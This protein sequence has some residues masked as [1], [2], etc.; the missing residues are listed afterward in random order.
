M[1]ALITNSIRRTAAGAASAAAAAVYQSDYEMDSL[2]WLM[3]IYSVAGVINTIALRCCCCCN[4]ANLMKT[5]W[6]W[7]AGQLVHL[8]RRNLAQTVS[9]VVYEYSWNVRRSEIMKSR[10][11]TQSGTISFSSSEMLYVYVRWDGRSWRTFFQWFS[12]YRGISFCIGKA[13]SKSTKI[14]V[15]IHFPRFVC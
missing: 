14:L 3:Y 13:A 4:K 11:R 7:S 12:I 8:T 6:H 10:R 2:D 1:R 9:A 15:G 5:K